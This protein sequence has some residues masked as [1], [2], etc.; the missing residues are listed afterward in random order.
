MLLHGC[1]L[2]ERSYLL[3]GAESFLRSKPVNFAASQEIHR[4]YGTRKSLTV[5]TSARYLYLSWAN[6]IQSPRP[7]PTSWRS[8]LILSSHLWGERSSGGIWKFRTSSFKCYVDHSHT[9]YSSG[10]MDIRNW[11]HHVES[12]CIISFSD[13]RIDGC[14][15]DWHLQ[16]LRC[17]IPILFGYTE[18]NKQ[19]VKHSTYIF[20]YLSYMFRLPQRQWLRLCSRNT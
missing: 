11:V 6:S 12:R 19:T 8:I 9:M 17:R 20:M 15:S 4:I 13:T 1:V 18:I 3:H 10:N 2:G 16:I 7:P 14:T 5:P